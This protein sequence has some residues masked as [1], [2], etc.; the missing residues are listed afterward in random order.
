MSYSLGLDL[1]TTASAVAINRAGDVSM[2]LRGHQDLVI[3]SV[4]HL[5]RDGDFR[6]GEAAVRRATDDPAGIAREFK[7]RFGDPQPLILNGSPVAAN[8][9]MLRL[10]THL[11]ETVAA[12]L[13]ESPQQIVV[14]H[15]ANWGDYKVALLA[16]TLANSSLPPHRLITEP[17]AAAIHDA[18]Q[19]RIEPGTTIAVYDLGGGTFDVAL[20]RKLDAGWEIVGRPSGIER[21]G[22]IDF[23]TAVLHH[24]VSTLGIDLSTFDADDA[25][26]RTAMIRL[27][28]EC[29]SAKHALS[30]DTST[31]IPV[32]LPGVSDSVRMTRGELEQLIA[33]TLARTFE[34]FDAMV[35]ASPISMADIDRVL[36]VGGSSRIPLVAQRV[37]MHT[38]R[39][40]ATDRHPK[41]AIALGAAASLAGPTTRWTEPLKVID[42]PELPPAPP[43]PSPDL[44]TPTDAT[45]SKS[46]NAAQ[47][48]PESDRVTIAD[49]YQLPHISDGPLPDFLAR[50]ADTAPPVEPGL[51]SSSSPGG[52]KVS[53]PM[54]TSPSAAPPPLVTPP[55]PA[56]PPPRLVEHASQSQPSN[57]TRVLA[58]SAPTRSESAP[59][60]EERVQ[61][62]R[63]A[64]W[65]WGAVF[66]IAAF[67]GAITYVALRPASESVESETAATAADDI[68]GVESQAGTSEGGDLEAGQGEGASVGDGESESQEFAT[69]CDASSLP[70]PSVVYRVSDVP[71]N[72]EEQ[73]LNGRNVPS[74]TEVNG[75]ASEPLTVFP[76]FSELDLTYQHCELDARG[77][78]WWGVNFGGGV[79][80]ASTRFIEPLP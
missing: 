10:A 67:A 42:E 56:A 57:P 78:A 65:F 26:A 60:S 22:G 4:V 77:R 52:P 69:S 76:E 61:T 23:D 47:A 79:V 20:L 38:H 80:W 73:G 14:S 21:L 51:P 1:G 33:P 19:L 12:D 30:A 5:S 49:M 13:G 16:D 39:P 25:A 36:L 72:D 43:M 53:P 63:G 28:E 8:D 17:E 31:A 27:R 74:L 44:A 37:A 46:A 35:E 59:V 71:D 32:L 45:S 34:V 6:I 29:Q 62:R 48:A 75:V 15:P 41:H 68:D 2:F 50:R 55:S 64:G 11:V 54:P 7:R 58:Q 70:D 18:S 40:I 24:V 66:V 9:L 3:P